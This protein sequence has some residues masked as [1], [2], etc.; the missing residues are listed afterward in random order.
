MFLSQGEDTMSDNGSLDMIPLEIGKDFQLPS[1]EQQS[2][3]LLEIELADQT[4]NEYLSNNVEDEASTLTKSMQ[5]IRRKKNRLA[6][7]KCREKKKERIRTLEDE[8]RSLL[9]ENFTLKRTNIELEEKLQEQELRLKNIQYY[10]Q[11]NS[12]KD[13]TTFQLT[14]LVP[15]QQQPQQPQQQQ[16]QQQQHLEDKHSVVPVSNISLGH[17]RHHTSMAPSHSPIYFTNCW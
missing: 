11:N 7:Q 9:D 6:A 15:L 1:T 12:T 17:Y 13:D 3:T 16:Q 4:S 14:S 8:I 5:L 10:N 2:R